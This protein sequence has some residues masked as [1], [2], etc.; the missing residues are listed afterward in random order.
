MREYKFREL[1]EDLLVAYEKASKNKRSKTKRLSF[2]MN[3]ET[4]IIALAGSIM[5][6]SYEIRPS[7]CFIVTSPV[8]REVVASD[9]RDRIV[10]HYIYEFLNPYLE[11][12]LIY[13]CYS[14]R[15]DKGTSFGVDRLEHH[16]RSCSDN[17]KKR[18]Y[19][20]QL[21][22]VGYFM[23]IN[24]SVLYDKALRLIT[25]I[26]KSEEA[27]NIPLEKFKIQ[28]YLIKKVIFNDP[29]KDAIYRGNPALR[30]DI[31]ASKT[32]AHSPPNCGL[33]IGNLTSQLFS[34]L[35]L[36]D[37]DQYIKR[38]LKV[39]HYGRYVDDFY[40]IDT[41]RT[42]LHSLISPIRNYLQQEVSLDIHPNKIH[43]TEVKKG[44]TFLG[45]HQKPYRR[46]IK[47]K[48]LKLIQRNMSSLN[49][50]Y[51]HCLEDKNVRDKVLAVTNSYLGLLNETKS[52]RIKKQRLLRD[53]LVLKF[54]YGNNYLQKVIQY[55]KMKT[56]SK[57]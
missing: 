36:N 32:L 26:S 44:I 49:R 7:T 24:R 35:Y 37:F 20:L 17:Y 5:D 27:K 52:F 51:A 8:K 41:D 23:H 40:L 54:G 53:M 55:K 29:L 30:K 38:N 46:Y 34:N 57:E 11:K 16:I 28:T 21:D 22:I 14:C 48:T 15:K 56:Y 47:S 50:K 45:I 18:C 33:P 43:I 3:F 6:Y 39:K 13:D 25:K 1:V 9:F 2:D 12:H 10:H 42:Y 4:E 19:V 31:P